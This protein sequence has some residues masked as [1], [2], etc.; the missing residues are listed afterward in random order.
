MGGAEDAEDRACEATAAHRR[1][2]R[3]RVARPE[4]DEAVEAEH[5][6][7]QQA[8]SPHGDGAGDLSGRG[9]LRAGA[10]ARGR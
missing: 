2:T 5:W 4:R 7:E 9:V 6:G 1:F 10:D 3:K 8:T